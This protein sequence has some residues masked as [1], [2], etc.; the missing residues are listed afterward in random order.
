MLTLTTDVNFYIK[1]YLLDYSI[2]NNSNGNRN[3]EILIN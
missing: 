3:A 1:K 2:R